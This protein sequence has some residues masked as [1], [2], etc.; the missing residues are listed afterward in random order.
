MIKLEKKNTEDI[1]ALTPLQEGMLFHYLKEPDNSLYFVQL[2]LEISG[3]I[4]IDFFKEAWNAVVNNHEMLRTV[5]RWEKLASPI[6]IIL[7]KHDVNFTYRDLAIECDNK[8]YRVEELKKSDLSKGFDLANDVPFRISLIKKSSEKYELIISNHHILY[9]GWS[10]GIIIK[11]FFESYQ[12]LLQNKAFQPSNKNKFKDYITITQEFDKKKHKEFWGK[13]L[14]GFENKTELPL[15]NGLTKGIVAFEEYSNYITESETEKINLFLQS[16]GF[17]L[18]SLVYSSF[19]ILLSKCTNSNDVVFGI[20]VSGRT[21]QIGNIE[22]IVGLFTNTIPL[23]LRLSENKNIKDLLQDISNEIL[24]REEYENTPI[25]EI[26]AASGLTEGQLFNSIVTV[27]NYPLDS[28]LTNLTS[29]SI[30]SFSSFEKTNYD[31]TFNVRSNSRLEVRI[32]YNTNLF[33]K[34]NIERIIHYFFRIMLSISEEKQVEFGGL[35]IL[36]SE[37]KE[38]LLEK[39]NNSTSDPI[40]KTIPELFYEQVSSAPEGIALVYKNKTISYF[41]LNKRSERLAEMLIN[42]FEIKTGDHIAVL[43]D[44]SDYTIIAFLSILK[45]DATYIPIDP[46]LPSERLDFI[47]NDVCPKVLL[48]N[49]EY[50]DDVILYGVPI[51]NLDLDISDGPNPDNSELIRN[52]SYENKPAYIMYTSGSTGSPKGV[53]VNSAGII[54]LVK[55]SNYLVIRSQDNILGLSNPSF[56]G[57]TFDIWGALLNGAT[58]VIPGKNI[59]DDYPVFSDTINENRITIA[60]LT[61]ALFNSVVDNCITCLSG[62]RKV[63]FGGELVSVKHV[64]SFFKKYGKGRLIHVYGPTE[65]TTFST[66]FEVNSLENEYH[67]IPI[68]RPLSNTKCYVLDQNRMLMPKGAPGELYLSGDGRAAGYLNQPFLTNQVFVED[69]F[70]KDKMYRTGDCVKWLDDGTIQFLG[71]KDDQVKIRGYRIELSEISFV[72]KQHK[73]VEECILVVNKDGAENKELI[74]Y[75]V[76]N[77]KCEVQDLRNYILEKLP[78]YMVPTHFIIL[79]EL[80][81]NVNGKVDKKLLPSI[82]KEQTSEFEL[83]SNDTEKK[84]RQIWSEVLKIDQ[85]QIGIQSNFFD[86]GGHSLKATALCSLMHK[87]FNIRVPIAEIFK[88]PTIK[89]ISAFVEESLTE[90]FVDLPIA[91]VT[92]YYPVSPAQKRLFILQQID[93]GNIGYNMPV[94]IEL[95]AGLSTT[96]LN[97]VF[98][99][100][101]E[102]HQGFRTSFHLVGNEP[103][104]S[105]EKEIRPEIKTYSCD[106]SELESLKAG[107]ALP[108][109]LDEAPLMRIAHVLVKGG[110]NFLLIDMHHIITDGVSS[111][112][113]KKEFALLHKDI[114][115]PTLKFQYKDYAVWLKTALQQARIREH[116][117]YW[118]N[119]FSDEVPAL[120][121]PYDFHRPAEKDFQG[122]TFTFKLSEKESKAIRL[123]CKENEATLYMSFM[124]IF[125]VWLACLSGQEDIVIGSPMAGRLHPALD[126]IIGIF[127]NTIAIRS[128]PEGDKT[129]EQFLKEVKEQV[130]LGHEH[131][132]YPFE[133]L[134][135]KLSLSG[136]L[137]RN[138]IFDV[139]FT[140]QNQAQDGLVGYTEQ[141]KHVSSSAKFDLRLDAL[142]IPNNILLSVEYST[143]LFKPDTID[144]LIIYLRNILSAVSK[145]PKIKLREIEIISPKEKKVLLDTLNRTE[146]NYFRDKGVH[147]FF[148]SQVRKGPV[149]IALTIDGLSVTYLE[150]NKLSNQLAHLLISK[151]VKSGTVVGL[152]YDKN[153]SMIISI[154]AILKSGATYLPIDPDYPEERKLFMLT[155]SKAEF[156]LIQDESKKI[157][158]NVSEEIIF[159]NKNECDAYSIQNPDLRLSSS[160]AAY[161]IYTSGTTGTPKGTIISHGNVISLLC[162]KPSNFNFNSNDTWT[163]FHSYCFDFSVWEIFGALLNGGKLVLIQK[164]KARDANQFVDTL[165]NEKVTILNQTPTAFRNIINN[166]L[167]RKEKLLSLRYVIF[168][169]EQLNPMILKEW[170]ERYPSIKLINMY[171][172]T[173]TTVHVTYKEITR[174]EIESGKSNIGI[175]LPTLT[176][177]VMDKY[178]RLVPQGVFGE[179]FVGGEGICKG[180][181]N[182]EELM[183]EKFIQNPYRHH[184][185][186]YRTGDVVRLNNDFEL[187]YHGRKDSQVKLRGYR[188]EPTEIIHRLLQYGSIKDVVVLLEKNN[189]EDFLC[190]Y[191]VASKEIEQTELR[192]YLSDTL[193]EYMIPAFFV[194]IDHIPLNLNGKLEKKLLPKPVIRRDQNYIIAGNDIENDILNIW[195]DILGHSKEKISILDNF[196]E[197]GGNSLN[198][199][200]VISKINETYEEDLPVIALFKYPTI[201]AIGKFLNLKRKKTY[202]ESDNKIASINQKDKMVNTLKKLRRTK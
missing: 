182:E 19:G 167:K 16:N 18:A 145:N 110:R 72:L 27:E 104:Q 143:A 17:S 114:S 49:S 190:V 5:F 108:F 54:R 152:I 181:I 6:Q 31:F 22:N 165:I 38:I 86:L 84:L 80:P 147:E 139:M 73:N 66:Y 194:K 161:I 156:L 180:Y 172:I 99:I 179:L 191:Y 169:G 202:S 200:N 164:E 187:E 109:K 133:D 68:G 102:R 55:S 124:A 13:Y 33:E 176:T 112:I 184:E 24:S 151:G 157:K 91:D 185:K 98:T 199:I 129:F 113:L 189:S 63:L 87:A 75:I 130:L 30:N 51:I 137:S 174:K 39:F 131:Q 128:K 3:E 141:D 138:P 105:I 175:S 77:S 57:S 65:N 76:T 29:L 23:R 34:R 60:F 82:K 107:F 186:I 71:R 92:E 177:Y 10:N 89:G 101:Y 43:A 120:T 20:T 61:T 146:I 201:E 183:K 74:V 142:E 81:L 12:A 11:E 78:A 52:D 97:K 70:N 14:S 168:G 135:D 159:N 44:Y 196:F 69:P 36:N 144:R 59:L 166:E 178:L 58:L 115:L 119:L 116:E 94:L 100:L 53:I 25:L 41:E 132:E 163:M 126:N 67:T 118:L 85:G 4:N 170:A 150:L 88:S 26:N 37:E 45:A 95:E 122:A 125:N 48:I 154:M 7:K 8:V 2:S 117:L 79:D 162:N 134:V 121:L 96:K 173:E 47:I 123:L 127:V 93:P 90:C 106:E 171:G 158:V 198:A 136:D 111:E 195:S 160:D 46:S 153:F 103:K 21:L 40:E 1:L 28:A 149:N 32:K 15:V 197:I 140:L 83:P 9:D 56:D 50:F 35:D 188:I 148:E 193:P 155:N 42:E 192:S 64:N 62:I